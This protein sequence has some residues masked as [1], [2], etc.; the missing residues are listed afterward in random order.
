MAP[1]SR[2]GRCGDASEF[3]EL[4]GFLPL[5]A[6]VANGH[7]AMYDFLCELPGAGL[8][9]RLRAQPGRASAGTCML[10]EC[11]REYTAS[12]RN[13]TPPWEPPRPP[14]ADVVALPC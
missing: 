1:S 11:A 6:V 9:D 10:A 8:D 14:C 3:C 7:R 4:T 2:H 5:H 12:A 13:P